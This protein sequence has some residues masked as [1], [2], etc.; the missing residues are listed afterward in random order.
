[1][2]EVSARVRAAGYVA[3]SP[4]VR[5]SE[6][7]VDR[8]E[9]RLI[10]GPSGSGKTTFILAALGVLKHILGGFVEGEVR[11]AGVD[12]LS[13][14]GYAEL[15]R[16]VGVVLQEPEKQIAMPTPLDELTFILE[17]Y[18][19]EREEAARRARRLLDAFGLGGKA[20]ESV[21]RLS[22]GERRRLTLAAS[23]AHDP[24]VI[25]MDEPTASLDPWGIGEL[26]AS[27]A[28][29]AKE[30]AVVVAEHKP[31]YFSDLSSGTYYAAGG[32]LAE[33]DY[34]PRRLEALGV[35]AGAWTC[36]EPGGAPGSIV[37]EA[38]GLEVGYR[39][40]RVAGPLDL[41]LR[42]GEA[43]AVVGPNG[44]G[45]TTL[46]KTLAGLI[47]RLGGEVRAS[48]RPF[49]VPQV[50]DYLFVER[51]VEGELRDAARRGGAGL[52]ELESLYPWYS[53][54]RGRSPLRLSHGQKRWLSLLV[55][56]GYSGRALLLDEPS[57]G[58]DLSLLRE[59]ARLIR[60]LKGRGAA[61]LISTHDPRIVAEVADRAYVLSGG[62][63][64]EADRCRLVRELYRAA[65]V[66]QWPGAG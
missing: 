35:D 31:V 36:R 47:R 45:K 56:Y 44:S 55:A 17:N 18:G 13:P 33:V 50:P 39:E 42:G 53:E 62:R 38:R 4:V 65:G 60:E 27:L 12:P 7:S 32:R 51:T 57:T 20:S 29:L 23:L 61:V 22:I 58:L 1:M 54:A 6:I 16:R 21:E 59:L 9:L 10:V 2:P 46:L 63:L 52:G 25:F 40:R 11:I 64:R 28:A 3:G 34:D 5:D 8:G 19:V 49:Y 30:R 14:E 37:L 24:P 48:A 66:A 26:R 41:E 43:V 15:A